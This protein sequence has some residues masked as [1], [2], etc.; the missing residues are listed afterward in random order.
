MAGIV[1][2]VIGGPTAGGKSDIAEVLCDAVN[3]VIINA[4]SLQIYKGL[5]LLTAQPVIQPQRHYLYSHMEPWD[6]CEVVRWLQLV[7]E[8]LEATLR[9][10]KQPIVVGGTGF[11]LKVLLEGIAQIPQVP[12]H[13]VQEAE[14]LANTHGITY[15][16]EKLKALDPLVPAYIKPT[17]HQRVIRYWSVLTGTGKPLQSWYQ[18]QVPKQRQAIRVVCMRERDILY[19]RINQRFVSMW[20]GGIIDEVQVFRTTYHSIDNNYAEKAIGYHE[21]N[22]YL[23]GECSAQQ[24]IE[25]AQ[26]KTRQY[27]KRQL[28]WFRHQYGADVIL[29]EPELNVDKILMFCHKSGMQDL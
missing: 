9:E 22:A 15:V 2:I 3:G 20:N 23:R 10:G 19:Q 17:D 12:D 1:P 8:L 16:Y 18:L 28:T 29:T 25:T 7:E 24:A 6:K 13:I 21:V 27:A 11:Y 26:T 5:P 14:S 4:D